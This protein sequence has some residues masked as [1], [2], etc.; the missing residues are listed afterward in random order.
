MQSEHNSFHEAIIRYA[1]AH[2]PWR[3]VC[4]TEAT[5]AAFRF[6][7]QL[8]CDGA[9]VRIISPAMAREARRVAFPVVNYS[10]WLDNPGVPTVRRDDAAMGKICAEHLL[11]K[12]FRRFGVVGVPGGWFI[13]ARRASFVATVAAVGLGSGLSCHAIESCPLTAADH[14][15][16]R[17]W[18]ASLRPPVGLFLT[19]DED[20]P[21]LMEVCREVG[22]KIPQDVA[23]V[24]GFGHAD[25]VHACVP[26]LSAAWEDG[27][28]MGWRAAEYL[29]RL[30]SGHTHSVKTVVVPPYGFEALG[31]SDTVAVDD[32]VVARAVAYI[33]THAGEKINIADVARQVSVA[34]VTLERRF[35]RAMGS[36]LHAYLTRERVELAKDYLRTESSLSLNAIANRCGFANR[37]RLNLVFRRFLL[38]SPAAW[39]H[40]ARK[41]AG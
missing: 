23:V 28:A 3:V 18:L 7:R 4:S 20:A 1:A 33:R 36:S 32:A 40:E 41:K 39:R 27:A 38:A 19:D 13:E 24:A 29:D 10:S 9:L 11:E 5:V 15:K 30:M 2:G 37:K 26:A 8:D 6:L 31:S 25:T 12:G 14:E 21:V 17:H 16:F 35:R 34:R 22:W